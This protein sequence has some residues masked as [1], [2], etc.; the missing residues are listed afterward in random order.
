MWI[1]LDS[2][3]PDPDNLMELEPD[4]GKMADEWRLTLDT[5]HLVLK[6]IGDSNVLPLIH[7]M[8]VFFWRLSLQPEGLAYLHHVLSFDLL[9]AYLNGLEELT[10]S[11]PQLSYLQFPTPPQ[12]E[13]QPLPEDFLLRG[14]V[15]A[16]GIFP[17][18]W[19]ENA[20]TDLDE[21]SIE[22]PFM[23][24]QRALRVKWLGIQLAKAV[25]EIP[26]DNDDPSKIPNDDYGSSKISNDDDGPS[27][28]KEQRRWLQWDPRTDRFSAVSGNKLSIAS[29]YAN[30]RQAQLSPSDWNPE[31]SAEADHGGHGNANLPGVQT[32]P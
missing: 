32:P 8:L 14:Q 4:T 21:R 24:K 17:L 15:Y 30:S 20:S 11:N 18:S 31:R 25:L 26:K 1:W 2:D 13:E 19:F 3:C 27:P 23:T 5:F 6:R 7:V 29:M 12:G 28:D 16:D 22:Q 9:S 10:E